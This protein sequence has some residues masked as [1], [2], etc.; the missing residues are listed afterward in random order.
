M[1]CG[2]GLEVT[3]ALRRRQQWLV[4]KGMLRERDGLLSARPRLLVE[5]QRRDFEET[6]SKLQRKLGL[7]QL[8]AGELDH[9]GCSQVRSVRLVS[10]RFAI[11][12]KGGEFTLIPWRQVTQVRKSSGIAMG[13]RTE[14][15]F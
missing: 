1:Q 14:I 2:F 12:Q 6:G 3:K 13:D 8:N 9:T 4:Q 11:M 5:L 7:K 15:S 10:G